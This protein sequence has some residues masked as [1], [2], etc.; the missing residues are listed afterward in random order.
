[1]IPTKLTTEPP[2]TESMLRCRLSVVY[3]DSEGKWRC[4]EAEWQRM[5]RAQEKKRA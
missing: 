3:Q 2:P 1:M 5:V 4:S